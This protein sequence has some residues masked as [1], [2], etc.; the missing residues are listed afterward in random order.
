MEL[1]GTPDYAA[2][3]QAERDLIRML[4]LEIRT[5]ATEL[6]KRTGGGRRRVWDLRSAARRA[7]RRQHQVA[8]MLD[9]AADLVPRAYNDYVQA[10]ESL[11]RPER[12]SQGWN[13]REDGKK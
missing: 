10:F 8:D 6:E 12:G 9:S 4:A 3:C 11:V 13:Y 2:Y 7:F 5:T 1:R